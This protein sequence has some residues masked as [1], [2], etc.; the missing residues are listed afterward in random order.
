MLY[1]HIFFLDDCACMYLHV[2][3]GS[4]PPRGAAGQPQNLVRTAMLLDPPLPSVRGGTVLSL[5]VQVHETLETGCRGYTKLRD[6]A[7]ELD[8]GLDEGV[9]TLYDV[10]ND[11]LSGSH[12]RLSCG[13]DTQ[14]FK[15][16]VRTWDAFK[17]IRETCCGMGGISTGASFIGFDT[18]VFND[19][20]ELACRAIQANQGLVIPGDISDVRV[21]KAMHGV[22]PARRGILTAGFPCQPY[23]IQGDG[24]GL[25]DSRG[26]TLSHVLR[27]AWL[28]QVDG[29]LLENVTEVTQHP[30]TMALL[31][32]FA[33]LCHMHQSTCVLD[34]ADQWPCKRKR[35]WHLMLPA[36]LPKLEL[37]AWPIP[38]TRPAIRQVI[39]TWALWSTEDEA[40]LT[41][42]EQ[43]MQAYHDPAFGHD[44]RQYDMQG[45]APTVLHSLGSTFS[46]C[47]CG[48]RKQGLSMARLRQGGLRGQGVVSEL[49]GQ[50]RFAH[51]QELALLQGVPPRYHHV[52]PARDALCLIG[53]VVASPLQALWIFSQVQVW[54]DAL[55]GRPALDPLRTLDAY[56]HMLL[57]QRLELWA[58]PDMFQKRQIQLVAHASQSVISVCT[59]VTVRQL[60]EAEQKLAGP[61]MSI[62]VMVAG[63]VVEPDAFLLASQVYE[64]QHLPKRQAR[65]VPR[66]PQAQP[67]SDSALWWGLQA[68]LTASQLHTYTRVLPSSF[69]VSFRPWLCKMLHCPSCHLCMMRRLFCVASWP[70]AIGLC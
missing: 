33:K 3:V 24:G 5:V 51:P 61:G 67:A 8:T 53:Q 25:Q 59:P 21:V 35:W 43:E 57:S 34:L 18:A 63:Q 45:S 4:R 46:P 10:R 26:S 14:F 32:D 31:S 19:R 6:E 1:I 69:F 54:L 49:T 37:Q 17:T 66:I 15:R 64:V 42:T 28:L 38:A 29:L 39:P 52:S 41:W 70:E 56:K 9:W 13:Q 30:D 60:V 62:S 68:V 23:S 2:A 12:F 36:D 11:G 50:V 16:P 22:Q 55:V 65:D 20:S 40:S 7:F 58:T 47:P 44:P 27:A 48:C